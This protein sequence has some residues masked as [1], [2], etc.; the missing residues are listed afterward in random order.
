M[1]KIKI[2]VICLLVCCVLAVVGLYKIRC[3]HLSSDAKVNVNKNTEIREA[4]VISEDESGNEYR[5]VLHKTDGCVLIDG[6]GNELSAEYDDI[7]DLSAGQQYL[8]IFRDN[9]IGYM[10]LSGNLICEPQF[11]EAGESETLNGHETAIIREEQGYC[12]IDLDDNNNRISDYYEE[13]YPFTETQSLYARVKLGGKWHLVNTDFEILNLGDEFSDG[14]DSIEKPDLLSLTIA[15][16]CE[17]NGYLI[18]LLPMEGKG[19]EIVD[20]IAG[21]HITDNYDDVYAMIEN[22]SG[23]G[24]WLSG[25]GVVIEPEFDSISGF[26]EYEADSSYL[27]ADTMKNG[28]YG[29]LVMLKY[30]DVS[31]AIKPEYDERIQ[32]NTKAIAVAVKDGKYGFVDLVTRKYTESDWSSIEP[33]NCDETTAVCADGTISFVQR[34]GNHVEYPAYTYVGDFYDGFIVVQDKVSGKYGIYDFDSLTDVITG[35]YDYIERLG[36]SEYYLLE[37]DN[38]KSLAVVRRDIDTDEVSFTVVLDGLEY[39]D[40]DHFE[41]DSVTVGYTDESG[42]MVYEIYHFYWDTIY[43]LFETEKGCYTEGFISMDSLK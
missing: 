28:K 22:E 8:R 3:E 40:V 33:Y 15:A 11:M 17:E 41:N 18:S 10:D 29:T 2:W 31:E 25:K 1:K 4:N 20:T 30:S 42:N 27:I 19:P 6:N 37:K 24:I 35:E 13:A 36:E 9:L 23:K 12:F 21:Y 7:Q 26:Y 14:F 43:S 34:N 38:M 32:F 39:I 16:N 5:A